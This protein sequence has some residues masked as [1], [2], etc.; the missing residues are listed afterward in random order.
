MDPESLT[1]WIGL[2][3]A[4]P[5]LARMGHAQ[6]VADRNLGLGWLYYAL[7]RT[8]RP[9]AAVVIGSY[10]GFVPLVLGR[11]L[12]DNS[13]GGEVAFIDPSFV[14]DFWKDAAAVRRYF[15]GLR[16]TNITHHLQTTQEFVRSPAYDELGS[17]GLVFVDGFHSAEQARFDFEAFADRLAPGGMI[18][19]HDS[20]WRM[21]TGLYGSDRH[22]V[23]GVVDFVAELKR[24][25]QWQVFDVP[26]GD[27]VTIVRQS[28]VPPPPSRRRSAAATLL[29]A[30]AAP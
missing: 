10:R 2:L 25:P 13:E 23:H 9:A 15:A 8:I 6:R 5:D 21:A 14:D 17:V 3:F 30:G 16:V 7:A 18:L 11:A 29:A 28:A 24:Q 1:E 27:G 22:Y 4:H 19:L 12:A 20:V 26:C